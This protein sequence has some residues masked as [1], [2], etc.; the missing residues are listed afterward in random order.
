MGKS[1]HGIALELFKILNEDKYNFRGQTIN[2]NRKKIISDRNSTSIPSIRLESKFKPGFKSLPKKN[3][4]RVA[5][6]GD[7]VL[8]I[9]TDDHDPPHFHVDSENYSAKYHID[10]ITVYKVLRGSIRGV[11][12]RRLIKWA[13]ENQEELKRIWEETRPTGE[14]AEVKISVSDLEDNSKEKTIPQS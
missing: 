8:R 12:K 10:S 13:E 11:K 7:M 2:R 4:K 14:P 3:L 1:F 9:H 5:Q 6:I